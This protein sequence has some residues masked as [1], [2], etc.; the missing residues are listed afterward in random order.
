MFIRHNILWILWTGIVLLL[1][2]TPGDEVP[3]FNWDFV[4]FDVLVHVF[5]YGFMVFSM[6][7]GFFKQ[8][9]YDVL[10]RKAYPIALIGV[11]FL[12]TVLEVT[13]LLVPGRFFDVKDLISNVFG[14]FIGYVTF[15]GIYFRI[16]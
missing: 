4:P 14:V 11:V 13:Q 7:S 10:R 3:E 16:V 8:R 12:S 1:S 6:L 5:M 2:L 15:K 9:D